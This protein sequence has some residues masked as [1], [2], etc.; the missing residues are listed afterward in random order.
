V[1]QLPQN[2]T[3]SVPATSKN[4]YRYLFAVPEFKENGK[5]D[6]DRLP[7]KDITIALK[8]SIQPKSVSLLASKKKLYF[9]YTDGE[10]KI[11]LPATLRTNLVD[12]VQ[13]EL[14]K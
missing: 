5:Y 9:K 2:E 3:A 14:S 13:V 1:Q 6:E 4:Q 12:V 8:T 7:A 11:K 10:L